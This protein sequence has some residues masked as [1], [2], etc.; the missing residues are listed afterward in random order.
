MPGVE[1]GDQEGGKVQSTELTLRGELFCTAG[2]RGEVRPGVVWSSRGLIPAPSCRGEVAL[3]LR[4]LWAQSPGTGH[5]RG[6]ATLGQPQACGR[7]VC[8]QVWGGASVTVPTR[9]SGLTGW[10][11]GELKQVSTLRP[12]ARSSLVWVP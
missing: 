10:C 4:V 9:E 6:D 5:S 8:C 3:Y 11:P 12:S 7:P 2:L 1:C